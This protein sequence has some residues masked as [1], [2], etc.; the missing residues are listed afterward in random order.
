MRRGGIGRGVGLS[1]L[2]V[3]TSRMA[4]GALAE[5]MVI[6]S[7]APGEDRK[8][9]RRH[10]SG[11]KAKTMSEEEEVTGRKVISINKAL[12]KMVKKIN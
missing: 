1:L 2:T 5:A 9:P 8:N 11:A 4:M 3:R 6:G 10:S 7:G 12:L